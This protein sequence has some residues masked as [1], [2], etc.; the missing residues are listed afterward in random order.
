MKSICLILLVGYLSLLPA[1]SALPVNA[2]KQP[3]VVFI[4]A[5][6]ASRHFGQTYDCDWVNTP[7]IDKLA[8]TGL[9]FDNCYVVSA[10]CAPCRANILTGRNTWQN[11]EA[12]N[13][14]NYFP[15][16]LPTFSKKLQDAGVFT[17]SRGKVWGPGRPADSKGV[18]NNF[19]LP[20]FTKNKKVSPGHAFA[21]F[22]AKRPTNTPFFYWHGSADP[23]RAYPAGSGLKSGKKLSDIDRVPAYWPDNDTVRS[24]MLDYALRVERFD[25]HVGEIVTELEKAKLLDNTLII[26]T[27]DHGMPFPRVKGHTFDD[28]HR[29]P[30]VMHWPKGIKHPGK[31]VDAL[32]SF[33][34][35][36][37]TFLELAGIDPS[38]SGMEITG[39]SITDIFT[40]ER[41]KQRPFLLIGRERFDVYARP[42]SAAG[43]G[44]PARGIR[45][46][47]YLY[48]HNFAPERWPCG[49]PELGFK[50]TDNSPTKSVIE[51]L[52]PGNPYWEHAFGKRPA[53]MLFNVK[54]DPDC[55]NNLTNDK[56]LATIIGRLKATMIAELKNQGD[57]RTLGVGK[58]DVFDNYPTPRKAPQGW[59]S[60]PIATKESQYFTP[61]QDL[62]G[63]N[64]RSEAVEGLP[65]VLVIGDSI[66]IGYM[67][68]LVEALEGVANV[69][70]PKANC[71][72]TTR[73]LEQL[74]K[75]LGKSEWDIIHF[76][77]G[78]HDLCY[79][80]PKSKV[81][82]NRD[83]VNGT[84][85]VPLEEYEKNLNSLVIQLKKT[86][87]K[88]IWASTT[89]VPK[90]EAGRRVG[91][92]IKYNAIA[93]K[94]MN[95]HGVTINDLH[96]LTASL[97]A[98]SFTKPGDVH[99]TPAG[100][101]KLA[102]QVAGTIKSALK[103]KEK[104]P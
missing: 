84:I 88:L 44:Y 92:E 103:A 97:P 1:L 86:R 5:D 30:M 14:R 55:V 26:V 53:D 6:D 36:A 58:G 3:N 39:K 22:L 40:G 10:K 17:G 32:V 69:Q 70:R 33:I 83:K 79:R 57:P 94:I 81:Q 47:D 15:S 98:T 54:K 48:V 24:D 62:E 42:G 56:S 91:D 89:F 51:K 34:D 20:S 2:E 38:Q 4:V 71:G 82:G 87:A 72:P 49:N 35:F 90:G 13:H 41:P 99:F 50:D 45:S 60:T 100:Y 78:L 46:G 93:E 18:I 67:K 101:A 23:H 75:W 61:K 64:A 21:N 9:V 102:S 27:S 80:H 11:G 29:V 66:S 63:L 37:P 7:N 95:K 77:W 8:K 19:A 31:R 16:D 76:N 73:G 85:A 59:G 74:K 25:V 28:A 96:Q 68:P 104:K 52:G 43:L 65:Q 12:A